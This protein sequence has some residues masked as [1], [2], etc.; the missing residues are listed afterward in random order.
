MAELLIRIVDKVN[1]DNAAQNQLC[2]KAGDILHVAPDGWTWGTEELSNPEW[3]ILKLPGMAPELFTD[4]MQMQ[5]VLVGNREHMTLKRAKCIDVSHPTVQQYIAS[6]HIITI[7][8]SVEQQAFLE[9]KLTKA[10]APV[11]V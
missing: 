2:F 4:L 11:V 8:L 3:R 5:M 7:E 1:P 6:G 10:I 9:R